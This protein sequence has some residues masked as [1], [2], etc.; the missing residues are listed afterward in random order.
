MCEGKGERQTITD[1]DG[2]YG[3][4]EG[5][6]RHPLQ[7]KNKFPFK[8]QIK[9]ISWITEKSMLLYAHNKKSLGSEISPPHVVYPAPPLS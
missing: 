4:G 9:V 1:Y 8:T 5:G 6:E 3:E 7:R 2:F